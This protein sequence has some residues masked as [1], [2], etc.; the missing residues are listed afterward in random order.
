M[1]TGHNFYDLNAGRGYPLDDIATAIDD[2]GAR[3]PD[4]LLVD[5]CLRYPDTLGD[6]AYVSAI[7]VSDKITSLVISVGDAM[8]DDSLRPVATLMVAGR[9]D[10]GRAYQL[11]GLQPGIAGWVVFGSLRTATYAGK[12]STPAQSLLLPKTARPYPA[13]PV[14]WVAKPQDEYKLED[15]V[16]LF[17]GRDVE[18]VRDAREI[19]GAVRDALVIRLT[20]DLNIVLPKYIGPCGT[21][22]ESNTCSKPAL[23]GINEVDPDDDGNIIIAFPDMSVTNVTNGLLVSTSLA[24]PDICPD[25]LTDS[26]ADTDFCGSELS[27]VSESDSPPE[28]SESSEPGASES[29]TVLEA[30][31]YPICKKFFT[32]DG[33]ASDQMDIVSGSWTLGVFPAGQLPQMCD[34]GTLFNVLIQ[35]MLVN[36]SGRPA[37]ALLPFDACPRAASVTY[38]TNVTGFS[39]VGRAGLVLDCVF[40]NGLPYYN[41]L[42]LDSKTQ[43]VALQR[44][45]G[46]YW[47]PPIVYA[48]GMHIGPGDW[49]TLSVTVTIPPSTPNRVDIAVTVRRLTGSP[50]VSQVYFQ[51]LGYS[52]FSLTDCRHGLVAET[53]GAAFFS[54]IGVTT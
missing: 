32:T 5:I 38:R 3:L 13:L 27:E 37:L 54:H 21:R 42:V 20:G 8:D 1:T 10:E 14:P 4:G 29:S 12:F 50:L 48:T 44:F 28:T 39:T 33:L 46:T 40:R 9:A 45:Q 19:A 16:K 22:P 31:E 47:T 35:R 6:Y 24:L 52:G 41:A 53:G 17:G 30:C 18:I 25:K 43:Q 49:Y 34:D 15:I 23:E 7:H 2:A 51:T 36:L 11:T 26:A